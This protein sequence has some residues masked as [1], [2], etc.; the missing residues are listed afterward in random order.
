MTPALKMVNT[1][2]ALSG[3]F[4][5]FSCALFVSACGGGGATQ[6]LPSNP[7]GTPAPSP[8]PLKDYGYLNDTGIVSLG[9]SDGLVG[10]CTDL[11]WGNDCKTGRDAGAT[12]NLNGKAGFD[13]TKIAED[14]TELSVLASDWACVKDNITGLLWE[15]K[16]DSGDHDWRRKFYNYDDLNKYQILEDGKKKKPLPSDIES[17]DN[18][19]GFINHTNSKRFCGS[20]FWRLPTSR[21]LLSIVDYG[22]SAP[23]PVVDNKFFNHLFPSAY[24]TSSGLARD[25]SVAWLVDFFGGTAFDYYRSFQHRVILVSG[26]TLDSFVRFE[27]SADGTEVLDKKNKLAWRRCV[28]GMHWNGSEC[29]G[30]AAQIGKDSVFNYAS[31]KRAADGKDWRLPN[32]KELESIVDR[33]KEN[34][35]IDL[36]IF[37][38]TP[39][40]WFWTSSPY[41]HIPTNTYWVVGFYVGNII[42]GHSASLSNYIRL[43]R[44]M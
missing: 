37:P 20:H 30:V 18:A 15:A 1:N 9:F 3:I 35:S 24:W 8:T 14:G 22:V 43:V 34:P 28:E 13:F 39:A 27:L 25:D 40:Y 19:L 4:I 10:N 17:M 21:E 38:K 11:F 12:N 6:E 26:D 44:D 2:K 32:V 23:D 16:K 31:N 36:T 7:T 42:D 33:T 29:S 5:V 41:A